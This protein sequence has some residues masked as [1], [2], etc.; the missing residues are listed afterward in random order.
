VLLLAFA[1][2]T[3][4]QS[5]PFEPASSVPMVLLTLLGLIAFI[6]VLGWLARKLGAT[7][8]VAGR[9]MRVVTALSL[10]T[11][12]RVALIE[13]GDKDRGGKQILVGITAQ[14]IS[15]LHTFDTPVIQQGPV[16]AEGVD[17]AS[18]LKSL[19]IKPEVGDGSAGEGKSRE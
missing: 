5:A 7:G 11:R 15:L 2:A 3:P 8:L 19:L 9:Q 14:S 17:F 6:V 12:E 4:A 10:G 18:R 16:D 13:V 1:A